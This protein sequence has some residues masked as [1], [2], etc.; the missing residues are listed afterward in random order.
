MYTR[1]IFQISSLI[2]VGQW[3]RLR[4]NVLSHYFTITNV[5]SH[6]TALSS[7]VSDAHFWSTMFSPSTKEENT[8]YEK[9]ASAKELRDEDHIILCVLKTLPFFSLFH[10]YLRLLGLSGSGKT[11]VSATSPQWHPNADTQLIICILPVLEQTCRKAG[12]GQCQEPASL[13]S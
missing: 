12:G 2:K 11:N 10:L 4:D 9:I 5:M 13:N 7:L 3:P 6:R 1:V 8:S